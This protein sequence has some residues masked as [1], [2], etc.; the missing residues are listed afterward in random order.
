M[1]NQLQLAEQASDLD[2]AFLNFQA[3]DIPAYSAVIVDS[4]NAISVNNIVDGIAVKLPAASTGQTVIGV[5]MEIIHGTTFTGGSPG[6]G[7]VRTIGP[8]VKA[9]A[10]AAVA[11]GVPV[12]TDASGTGTVVAQTAGKSQFAISLTAATASGDELALV[13]CGANNA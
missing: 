3:A 6:V 12:M 11:A 9:V 10:S 4:T 1:P 13:L 5:T 2:F 7:R 8:V